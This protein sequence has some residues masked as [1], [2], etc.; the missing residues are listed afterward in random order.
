LLFTGDSSLNSERPAAEYLAFGLSFACAFAKPTAGCAKAAA[1]ASFRPLN[2]RLLLSEI[3]MS[4]KQK[5][6]F[7]PSLSY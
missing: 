5:A 2:G 1:K 4:E 7:L 6:G 3:G